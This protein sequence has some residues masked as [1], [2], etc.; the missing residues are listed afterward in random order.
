[1]V[2]TE[3]LK[4]GVKLMN[5]VLV[6]FPCQLLHPIGKPLTLGLLKSLLGGSLLVIA[7]ARDGRRTPATSRRG[8][9]VRLSL[10]LNG[11]F[12][13]LVALWLFFSS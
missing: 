2:L 8:G 4:L 9:L 11:A 1:M 13:C 12:S 5:A 10:I 3:C 7:A 6:R